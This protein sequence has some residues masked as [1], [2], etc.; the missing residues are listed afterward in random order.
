MDDY[1]ERI[2]ETVHGNPSSVIVGETGSGKSTRVPLYIL[3]AFPEARIAVTQPRRV[4]VRSVSRYV[5]RLNGG[6][7]GNEIGYQVRF[8]DRTNE[9]TRANFMTDGILLHKLLS[10]PLLEEYDVVMVD[11]A[12]E[13]SL[14]IDWVLGLLKQT[15]KN[16]REAGRPDLKVIVA[17]AT[18]D[19]EKFAQYFDE[20]P[21]VEAPGRMFPVELNYEKQ[22]PRDVTKAAAQKVKE[23]INDG[24]DGDVLIFMPGEREINLTIREVESL[25]LPVEVLPL[26]GALPAE[27]QD[28]V[29]Q[30]CNR[31]KVIVATNI[32]ETSVTIDGVTSVIDS[33]L[34]KQ[35]RFNHQTGIGELRAWPHAKSGCEQR[36]GRAGRTAPGACYRLFTEA[37]FKGREDFQEPEIRHSDLAH[38]VLAM[39]AVGLNDVRKFDF[40]DRPNVE[41]FSQAIDKL[42]VLGALDEDENITELGRKMEDLPLSPE[43]ARM[44][45][46]AEKFRCVGS[47]CTV[48]AMM[49]TSVSVFVRPKDRKEQADEATKK[50][51]QNGSDFMRLLNAGREWSAT[52]FSNGWAHRNFL[53]PIRLEEAKE[54][55][56]QLMD[57]LRRVGISADRDVKDADSEAI[58]KCIAS[59]LINQLVVADG[60]FTYTTAGKGKLDDVFIHP[61]SAAFDIKPKLMI[62]ADIMATSKTYARVC[63]PVDPKWLLEIAP[64]LL[65]A[66]EEGTALDSEG[67]VVVRKTSHSLKSRPYDTLF[68]DEKVISGEEGATEFARFMAKGNVEMPCVIHNREV[69]SELRR[70]RIR[71]GGLFDLPNM[72]D[73]YRDK[74][75]GVSSIEGANILDPYLRL[76]LHELYSP[77]LLVQID[78]VFPNTFEVRGQSLY[79][80][81]SY[82]EYRNSHR[83]E[84]YVP[85]ELIAS[86][87]PE[88]LPKIGVQDRTRISFAS[89]G[90]STNVTASDLEGLRSAADQKILDE[91]W[92]DFRLPEF[93]SIKFEKGKNLP[94]F[95]SVGVRPVTCDT[96]FKKSEIFAWPGWKMTYDYLS[97]D[98]SYAFKVTYF[99]TAKEAE[100][101]VRLAHNR[102]DSEEKMAL[103]KEERERLLGPAKERYSQLLPVLRS[104]LADG[105]SSGLSVDDVRWIKDRL[106]MAGEC[107]QSAD[108]A[109]PGSAMELMDLIESKSESALIELK[110][111]QALVPEVKG[112]VETFSERVNW[113]MDRRYDELGMGYSEWISVGEKW[114]ELNKLLKEEDAFGHRLM[115][116]PDR[117]RELLQEIIAVVPEKRELSQEQLRLIEAM[118]GRDSGYTQVL[119]IRNGRLTEYFHPGSEPIRD[120]QIVPIG[121]SGRSLSASGSRLYF[122]YGSGSQGACYDLSDGDYFVGRDAYPFLRVEEDASYPYGLHA[123]ESVEM[124][125]DDSSYDS[126]QEEVYKPEA[127][128]TVMSEGGNVGS[129]LF[130]SLLKGLDGVRKGRRG[131]GKDRMDKEPVGT[132]S[133]PSK[134]EVQAE[135]MTDELRESLSSELAA[136]RFY[137]DKVLAT[138]KPELPKKGQK[139]DKTA[140]GILKVIGRA[141]ELKKQLATEI[142][143]ELAAADEADRIRGRVREVVRRAENAAGELHKLKDGQ[144]DWTDRFKRFMAMVEQLAVEQGEELNESARSKIRSGVS[145]LASLPTDP[146]DLDDQIELIL[147]EAM[148]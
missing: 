111:R 96:L 50:F 139:K 95:E 69:I 80:S 84:I 113:A 20:A 52:G 93:K 24:K 21:V 72:A 143:P 23:I 137:L 11:E 126:G 4:A 102:W 121:G 64:N 37:E 22:T 98:H 1:R 89:T 38:V 127:N 88:D 115:P 16:R 27:E 92:R 67:G 87:Q 34:I 114:R 105:S 57:R 56:T 117:A 9:G 71:S 14:N 85:A 128:P 55:R 46:E 47:I 125:Y 135:L 142:E 51:D 140:E 82:D 26:Y 43:I 97:E 59:G 6:E 106:E 74:L 90:L 45:I 58:Q 73:W 32:A 100:E 5:A 99:H 148:E 122:I 31:R 144:E 49:G 147:L 42:K 133:L 19:K 131:G 104:I 141:G 130:G 2:M 13:R 129:G 81:Y 83:A 40:I 36:K 33:G 145:G 35:N 8:E 70:L 103:L 63:Q 146:P 134:P 138:R 75:H 68:E 107:L 94:S 65:V 76:D 78:Q 108:D 79:V 25:G 136:A 109:N 60:H 44:V 66:R 120:S 101:S 62:A 18:I 53:S 110:R 86:L 29:F 77:E 7:V 17:S 61:S 28:R 91:A 112:E 54:I 12:H 30:P 118:S 48:A 123:L 15:Q 124:S 3:E 41:A 39:K 119:R 116:D 10:D 132:E